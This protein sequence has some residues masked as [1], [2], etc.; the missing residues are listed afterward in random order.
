MLSV[1]VL[2][3]VACE[4]AVSLAAEDSLAGASAVVVVA[5]VAAA[6]A[7]CLRLVRCLAA[8]R[9]AAAAGVRLLVLAAVAFGGSVR[10]LR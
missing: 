4:P 5:L 9:F 6:A 1:A 3:S 7:C 8:F 10:V 2:A